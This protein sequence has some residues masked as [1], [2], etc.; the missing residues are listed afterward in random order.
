MTNTYRKALWLLLHEPPLHWHNWRMGR[1]DKAA[2]RH[3]RKI[4]AA[5][6]SLVTTFPEAGRQ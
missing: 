4:I 2:K 3:A 6:G 1:N 5:T